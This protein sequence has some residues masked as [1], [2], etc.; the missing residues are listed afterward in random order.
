MNANLLTNLT[1]EASDLRKCVH[2]LSFSSS[3][4]IANRN[5]SINQTSTNTSLH[6][7]HTNCWSVRWQTTYYCMKEK[8]FSHELLF[9][10]SEQQC[11]CNK[12]S[13]AF[14]GTPSRKLPIKRFVIQISSRTDQGIKRL[15]TN[16]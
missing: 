6:K 2:V 15:L 7:I 4:R 5:R 9:Y 11:T 10:I 1:H 8:K 13:L 14:I 12:Y 3:L 16:H